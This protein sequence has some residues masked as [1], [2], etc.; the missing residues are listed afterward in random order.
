MIRLVRH[1]LNFRTTPLGQ[2]SLF[3]AYCTFENYWVSLIV[4]R[5][6]GFDLIAE[7][8]NCVG[9]FGEVLG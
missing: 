6:V 5:L 2:F 4:I 9:L 7:K 8:I 1:N 3:N